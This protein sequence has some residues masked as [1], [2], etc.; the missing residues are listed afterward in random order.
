MYWWSN[1]S[2]ERSLLEKRRFPFQTPLP[3]FELLRCQ[4]FWRKRLKFTLFPARESRKTLLPLGWCEKFGKVTTCG[5][6]RFIS[7][8]WNFLEH[9]RKLRKWRN[10]I[11]WRNNYLA[12]D[13]LKLI[14]R[15][16]Q[17]PNRQMTQESWSCSLSIF[18]ACVTFREETR[19]D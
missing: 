4:A 8:S 15:C 11:G 13:W 7:F 17:F 6:R 3:C 10:L 1:S 19:T 12:C 14:F 2:T 9:S 5:L 16:R 18:W